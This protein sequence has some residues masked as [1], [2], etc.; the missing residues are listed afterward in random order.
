MLLNIPLTLAKKLIAS[1]G[2]MI[3]PSNGYSMYPVIRPKDECHFSQANESDLRVGDILLF[4][5]RDGLLIG[6]RLVRVEGTLAN[7]SYICKGDTNLHPDQSVPFDRIIGKLTSIER[8]S[9]G[10][11]NRT[12]FSASRGMVSWGSV[13]V[14]L[15]FLSAWLRRW[16][17]ISFDVR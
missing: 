5:D 9:N 4:G 11:K 6:H 2:S 16:V 15:P 3:I 14:R 13:I 10:G 17:R 7:R 8:K 1:S 12:I